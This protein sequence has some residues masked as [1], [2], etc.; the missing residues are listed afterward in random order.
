MSVHKIITN[1]SPFIVPMV[2]ATVTGGCIIDAS[3]YRLQNYY[4]KKELETQKNTINKV[5]DI[6]AVGD[7]SKLEQLVENNKDTI[8]YILSNEFPNKQELSSYIK[9]VYRKINSTIYKN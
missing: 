9:K 1:I 5:S 2:V 8:K 6:L 7:L 3:R 4:L